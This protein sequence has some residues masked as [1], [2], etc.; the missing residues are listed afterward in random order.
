MNFHPPPN[1]LDAITFDNRFTRELPADPDTAIFRLQVM[2][3]CFSRVLPTKVARPQLVA[4]AQ[5]V[6]DLLDLTIDPFE[7]DEFAQVFAGNRLLAGMDPFAT[8]YGGH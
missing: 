6:V 2:C 5:E 7:S 8:C 4:Y 1:T 3:A